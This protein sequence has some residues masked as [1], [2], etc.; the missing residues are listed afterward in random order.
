[1][2]LLFLIN[3]SFGPSLCVCLHSF[4]LDTSTFVYLSTREDDS[5]L[6]RSSNRLTVSKQFSNIIHNALNSQR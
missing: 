4:L 5:L 6:V 1:M 2:W 3:P